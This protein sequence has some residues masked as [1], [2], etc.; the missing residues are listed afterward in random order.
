MGIC[1]QAGHTLGSSCAPKHPCPLK[2]TSLPLRLGVKP[3]QLLIEDPLDCT[4]GNTEVTCAE[5][6]VKTANSLLP[7]NLLD[8]TQTRNERLVGR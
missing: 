8:H 3:L 7:G 4:L 2:E 1:Y 6:L 5:P